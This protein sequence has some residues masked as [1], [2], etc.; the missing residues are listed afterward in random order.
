MWGSGCYAVPWSDGSLL[1]GATMEEAGFDERTTLGGVTA[2]A[3]AATGLLP[4]SARATLI[5]SR[6][7]LRPATPDGLPVVG[8]SATSPRV[9]WATGHYR[10]GILLAPLTASLVERAIVDGVYDE[11]VSALTPDRFS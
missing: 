10:N 9:W 3:T 2:L 4:A 11:A 7:G 6:A 5:E 1:V 8:P